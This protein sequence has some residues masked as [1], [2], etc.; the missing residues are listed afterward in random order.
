MDNTLADRLREAEAFMAIG[1]HCDDVDLRCGGTF[2]RLVRE[3]KRG[4]YVVSVENAYVNPAYE[5][6][7]AVEALATRRRESTR[8]SEVLGASRLEWLELESFYFNTSDP[9]TRVYPSFRS[10][11]ALMK[12]MKEVE[13]TGRIPVANADRFPECCER[14][15]Q[16]IREVSPQAIFTH[17][18][19]D[20]HPDH[21]AL[22]RFVEGIVQTLREQGMDIDLLFWEPGSA[23]PMAG[24]DPNLFVELS[25]EDVRTKHEAL[26]NYASQDTQ[27]RFWRGPAKYAERRARAYG[28]LVGVEFAETFSSS[29]G[30]ALGP[31]QHE[32]QF[33]PL[34]EAGRRPRETYPIGD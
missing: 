6:K 20:R 25:Q 33:L 7:D 10:L 19:D 18:P 17:S 13:L 27:E 2:H 29:R 15:T 34:V 24:F 8:A 30:P 32:A 9:H 21:Y 31:W 5:V 1:A 26:D 3:G 4:C 23:G 12:E 22:C 28:A 14:L 16:L 11:D